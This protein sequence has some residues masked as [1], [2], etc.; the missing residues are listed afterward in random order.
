MTP[1]LA[2]LLIGLLLLPFISGQNIT[3]IKKYPS[4]QA[5]PLKTA[6][7]PSQRVAT[8]INWKNTRESSRDSVES[9]PVAGDRIARR[10]SSMRSR[11]AASYSE[12]GSLLDAQA[13]FRNVSDL[14]R[15][16]PRALEI[17]MWAP[18]PSTWFSAGRRV[19]NVGKIISGLET[20]AIYLLQALAALAIIREPRR[21]ARWFV[22]AI[23]VCG[24]TALAF[25]VPNAGALYRFRYVFW[26]LLIVAAMSWPDVSFKKQRE[27][28][29]LK[30]V[31]LTV[32]IAG[33]LAATDACSSHGPAVNPQN[34]RLGLTNF[35]GTAFSAVY[36]SPTSAPDWQENLLASSR[37]NDG[38]TLEIQFELNEKNVEWD[39]KVEGIDGHYAEWKNL[40]FDGVSEITL[41]LKLSP[42]PVV[43]AEVEQVLTR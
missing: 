12:A 39:L 25:V 17:G 11:F 42:T 2:V 43:V 24:V 32:V 34:P 16:V 9:G 22:L 29:G 14:L 5:G 36:L 13:E 15:Y 20:L 23:V 33:M 38:D 26:I 3:C 35:T 10:I 4:D 21:L 31:M 1:A 41:V 6:A 7:H 27:W 8:L 37:H 28:S 19:G 30:Q 40:K 18:F